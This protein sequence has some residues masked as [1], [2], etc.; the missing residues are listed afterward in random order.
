MRGL[1]CPKMAKSPPHSPQKMSKIILRR[2]NPSSL[3]GSLFLLQLIPGSLSHYSAG[4]IRGGHIFSIFC[5][6]FCAARPQDG[7]HQEA[8]MYV[9]MYV[10]KYVTCHSHMCFFTSNLPLQTLSHLVQQEWIKQFKQFRQYKQY[11][12]YK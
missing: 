4:N 5:K 12:Q 11:K 6:H 7:R 9:C 1:K 8:E 2:V 10:C 3:S